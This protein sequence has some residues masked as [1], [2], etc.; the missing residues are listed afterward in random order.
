METSLRRRREEIALL[1]KGE[2]NEDDI[3]AAKAKYHALSS[4]YAQ[5]SKAMNLP[6][7]RE[8]VSIDGRNGVDVNFGK[9]VANSENSGI[10]KAEGVNGLE[11]AKK[12][13]KKI[14]VTDVAIDKVTKSKVKLL[15]SEHN[16]KI[17]AI[18]KELLTVSKNENNSDEV[19]ILFELN[20]SKKFSQMG[21]EHVVNIFDNPM[22]YS[23]AKNG[24][25]NSL[26]LAH[27]HPSTQSFS[28]ADIGV[29]M[30]VDSLAGM[31]VVSNT[32]DVH[33]LFKSRKFNYKGAYDA[34]TA[35]K[36]S[37]G[38]YK[39]EHDLDIVKAFLKVAPKYGLLQY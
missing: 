20:S 11:Q 34:L 2:A 21:T 16:S 9:S 17:D 27:N 7:Q 32:G 39:P 24:E 19:A 14:F 12:R 36:K 3:L 31:S 15:S 13:D 37:F 22:A 26:F 35:I 5:F 6:Q 10:M 38:G 28:Y 29:L 23:L 30:Y 4:E 8:R 1:E 25:A 18:H 33:I